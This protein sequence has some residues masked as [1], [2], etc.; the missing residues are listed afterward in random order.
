MKSAR[1]MNYS[2]QISGGKMKR[3][4]IAAVFLAVGLLT[5]APSAHADSFG[6]YS[7]NAEVGFPTTALT[8]SFT[9]DL[10]T[11]AVSSVNVSATGLLS[12]GVGFTVD[13][14]DFTSTAGSF[15]T[16]EFNQTSADLFTT[17]S[18]GGKFELQMWYPTTVV[19]PTSTLC[20]A[21][22]ACTGQSELQD[23]VGDIGVELNPRVA[24]PEP[25]SLLLFC[26]GTLG[27]VGRRRSN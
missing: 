2:T 21:S 23:F 20:I 6:T 27:L 26:I 14:V 22:A 11:N 24:S 16:Q 10:T 19:T 7:V 3:L 25:S 8:G 12:A 9:L 5:L 15:L 17:S 13:S 4:V 1:L 18:S